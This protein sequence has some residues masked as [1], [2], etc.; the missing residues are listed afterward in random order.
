MF[1]NMLTDNFTYSLKF[2]KLDHY[3]LNGSRRPTK[4][5][6]LRAIM[7]IFDPPLGLIAHFLVYGKILL[8]KIWRAGTDWDEPLPEPL[9]N[10]LLEADLE[11]KPKLIR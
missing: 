11:K 9:F 7:S 6:V 10:Q 8:Q 1:W 4:R 3:V 2:A 5:E